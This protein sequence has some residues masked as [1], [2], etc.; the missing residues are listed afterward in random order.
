MR[1]SDA[2]S[3]HVEHGDRLGRVVEPRENGRQVVAEDLPHA[4]DARLYESSGRLHG[5][6]LLEAQVRRTRLCAALWIQRIGI[7]ADLFVD[8]LARVNHHAGSLFHT[9]QPPAD[10]ALCVEL[11]NAT[12][13]P[14]QAH[15]LGSVAHRVRDARDDGQHDETAGHRGGGRAGLPEEG[16][17]HDEG[18]HRRDDSGEPCGH[19]VQ[20]LRHGIALGRQEEHLLKVLL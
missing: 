5:C 15:V 18:A 11:V 4:R 6:S 16:Y 12:R 14:E 20:A 9:G 13:H 19:M 3:A 7:A 10:D 17:L 2:V 1:G 8:R